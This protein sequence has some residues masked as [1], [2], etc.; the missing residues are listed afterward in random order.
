MSKSLFAIRG[1]AFHGKWALPLVMLALS[2]CV[3]PTFDPA[4]AQTGLAPWEVA[5]KSVDNVD[6]IWGGVIIQVHHFEND[7]EVEVLAF[8]L[9]RG[10]RPI[11]RAPSQ[12]RFRIR[13]PGFVESL[14]FPEG[15]FLS[16]RG[17]LIGTRDG[18]IGKS[19][20]V[21]PIIADAQIRRWPPGYQFD[22]TRWSVGIG[23]VL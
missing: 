11:P 13:I 16:A 10:Q 14:D 6:V 15:L 4:G 3:A 22:Q 2:S 19:H 23:V 8:P 12:G 7:S 20:Y 18:V 1:N 21:Y 5:G 17:R 9:D